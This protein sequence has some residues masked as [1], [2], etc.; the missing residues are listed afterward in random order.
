MNPQKKPILYY[1]RSWFV[2]VLISLLFLV[3]AVLFV[4][5]LMWLLN[6]PPLGIVILSMVLLCCVLLYGWT[7][8]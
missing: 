4:P 2:Q 6:W 7:I 8:Y 3:F 1:R 5:T